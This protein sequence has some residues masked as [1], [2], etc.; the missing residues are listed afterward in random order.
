MTTRR[1]FLGWD[2]PLTASVC[3]HLLP[4]TSAACPPDFGADLVIVPT[5]QAGRRLREALARG[6]AASGTA[7]LSFRSL[8]PPAFLHEL[9]GDAGT[10]ASEIE[11]S[12]AWARVLFDADLR[13]LTGLFPR[14]QAGR[15]FRWALDTGR[16][17]QRLRH[18]V[19]EG[20]LDLAGVAC[21]HGQGLEE[22]ERWNDLASLEEAYRARMRE[23]GLRDPVDVLLSAARDAPMP[24]GVRRVILACVPDPTGLLVLALGRLAAS[25]AIDVL[26]HA[27]ETAAAG[28]DEWGRPRPEWWNGRRIDIPDEARNLRLT[29]RPADQADEV[30][31]VMAAD[32]AGRTPADFAVGVPDPE[33]APALAVALEERGLRVFNPAGR[34]AAAHPLYRLLCA[35]RELA[36]EA[37][38]SAVADWLRQADVLAWL[39]RE[40]QAD[41][42]ALLREL[43]EFQNEYLPESLDTFRERLA[44]GRAA[45]CYPT[46]AKILPELLAAQA[47][48]RS[49]EFGAALRA[50]LR[51]LYGDRIFHRGRVEDD[52]WCD[53]S[54][55]VADALETA[56]GPSVRAMGWLPAERFDLL[57][58]AVSNVRFYPDEAD[59]DLDLDGWLEIPWNDAP[60]LVITG[61]NEGR[62]PDGRIG[63]LFL[64]DALRRRLGLRDD[65]ARLARDASL[66]Q[67]MIESR[68]GRG[69]V[70]LIAGRTSAAGDPLRP[71]RLL[72]RCDDRDLPSR[73]ERLFAPAAAGRP[74]PPASVG[75]RLDARPPPDVPAEDLAPRVLRVTS[76]CE[77]LACP[78]RFYLSHVLGMA[79]LGDE[80]EEMNASAFGILVHHAMAGLGG[81]PAVG[82]ARSEEALF[83]LLGGRAERWIADR[84]GRSPPVAVAVQLESAL[85]RLRAAA[86]VQ[87][88]AFAEG[89]EIVRVEQA[90][91]GVRFGSVEL[92]GT[93]DRVE[94]HRESGRLRICD[95]K[96]SD[97]ALRPDEAHLGPPREGAAEYAHTTRRGRPA[98]WLDLQLP[99]YAWLQLE[100]R[101]EGDLPELA[102]FNLPASV[103]DTALSA[104]E[105]YDRAQHRSAIA[106]ARGVADD[107]AAGRYWP[108]AARV[109]HDNFTHLFRGDVEAGVDGGLFEAFLA[110]RRREAEA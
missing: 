62:V 86:R 52:E 69:R 32:A 17:L 98:C 110:E 19:A 76:F 40:R 23:A 55:A 29:G 68:R 108:P 45:A 57:L 14:A 4:S 51:Q 24:P 21:E 28:F 42:A 63:D 61:M 109:R 31:A 82:A 10:A 103:A 30:I 85:Q 65:A 35:W 25:R 72:L 107:I 58:D 38:Y 1:H 74:T 46:L 49:D 95:I 34:P 79:A 13:R 104:W 99:L 78:F 37:P 84:F 80:M 2:A 90:F 77:Y 64:P 5:R 73:V 26:V 39:V 3:G 91:R 89:W 33:V 27:P 88:E 6:A 106:C 75:F 9:A 41:A 50:R 53:L 54:R 92:R 8:T 105:G 48:A 81:V 96:T 44:G 18:A 101:E 93:L 67:A 102:Y 12:A 71:S 83:A 97:R 87:A 7:V 56:F 60:V 66:L 100:G 22:P 94:R 11:V 59:A 20:G 36:G 70:C 43:D 15:D 16:L 47:E